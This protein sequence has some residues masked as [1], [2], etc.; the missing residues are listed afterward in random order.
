MLQLVRPSEQSG[1]VVIMFLLS[2]VVTDHR[3]SVGGSLAH[4]V[5]LLLSLCPEGAALHVIVHIELSLQAL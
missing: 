2:L 4:C 3:F 5:D 1:P